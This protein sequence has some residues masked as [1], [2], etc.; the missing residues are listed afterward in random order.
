MVNI[1]PV[2]EA[3]QSV[4]SP[5]GGLY[6]ALRAGLN[7]GTVSPRRAAQFVQRALDIAADAVSRATALLQEL[8]RPEPPASA[9]ETR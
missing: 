5:F 1:T 9:E 4:A 7:N 6:L 2:T 3:G 8:Q